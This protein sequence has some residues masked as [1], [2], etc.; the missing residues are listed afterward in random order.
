[1]GNEKTNRKLLII[2]ESGTVSALE[3]CEI[4]DVTSAKFTPPLYMDNTPVHFKADICTETVISGER[5]YVFDIPTCMFESAKKTLDAIV[6]DKRRQEIEEIEKELKEM[7]TPNSARIR[8]GY[9]PIGWTIDEETRELYERYKALKP[10]LFKHHYCGTEINLAYI[11]EYGCT[12]GHHLPDDELLE[13]IK[14]DVDLCKRMVRLIS[15]STYG[16]TGEKHIFMGARGS[17][18]TLMLREKWIKDNFV[19]QL[20]TLGTSKL[21]KLDPNDNSFIK[22][23]ENNN[24][25]IN[26]KKKVVTVK[27]PDGSVIKVKCDKRDEFDPYVGTAL[28]LAYKEFGSKSKFRKYVDDIVA[29]QKKKGEM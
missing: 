27:K 5:G 25:W 3:W 23:L 22:R 6:A 8:C 4:K 7:G 21:P 10:E 29:K 26:E 18:K 24:I 20:L 11:D 28:A 17:G 1:M 9:A 2:D 13:Y 16:K 14:N 19:N 12:G 15:N